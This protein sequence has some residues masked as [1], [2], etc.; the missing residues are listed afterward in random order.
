ML[1][2][3]RSVSPF[4]TIYP[5]V[6]VIKIFTEELYITP[7]SETTCIFIVMN[8]G[9]QIGSKEVKIKLRPYIYLER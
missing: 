5:K 9:S 7:K 8:D 3:F 4:L 1:T 2:H 6:L